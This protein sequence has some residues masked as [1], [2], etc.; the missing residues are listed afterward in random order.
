MDT[1]PMGHFAYWT[2]RLL[3]GHFAY[4]TLRLLVILPTKHF[5][6]WTVRLLDSLPTTI[7]FAYYRD[8]SPTDCSSFYQQNYQSKIKSVGKLSRQ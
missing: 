4:W 3:L 2:V 1:S 8:S 7:H 6:Y 5:A